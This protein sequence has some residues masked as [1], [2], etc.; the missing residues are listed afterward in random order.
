MQL[1]ALALDAD[2]KGVETPLGDSAPAQ[3]VEDVVDISF[4][5]GH[6]VLYRRS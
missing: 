3:A 4:A 1:S 5:E 2:R 6:G